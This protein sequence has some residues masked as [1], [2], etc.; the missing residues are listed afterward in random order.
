MNKEEAETLLNNNRHLEG[1]YFQNK[2]ISHILIVPTS[3]EGYH[4][5]IDS[6]QLNRNGIS[7]LINSQYDDFK[8]IVL[9]D[10]WKFEQTKI[11]EIKNL[12]EVLSYIS[13]QT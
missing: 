7:G 12:E 1:K 11:L 3:R 6:I 13:N 5:V 8:I 4:E 2:I 9:L 10:F